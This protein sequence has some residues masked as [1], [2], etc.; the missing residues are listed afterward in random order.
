[1]KYSQSPLPDASEGWVLDRPW[2]NRE[3]TAE[4]QGIVFPPLPSGTS[5]PENPP[6]SRLGRLLL[7]GVTGN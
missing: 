6:Q 1:M 4:P 5:G 3:V 7:Y 2:R